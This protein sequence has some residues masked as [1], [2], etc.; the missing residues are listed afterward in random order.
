MT[1]QDLQALVA[2]VSTE[3][4]HRPFT[5][6]ASFNNRLRTTGGRMLLATENLEFNPKVFEAGDEAVRLGI[7]KHELCHYHLHQLHRGFRHRDADFRALLQQ[8]GGLRFTPQ[9]TPPAP[10]RYLYVCT[11]CGTPY[12]RKRRI[13]LRRLRCG[14]C[15]QRLRLV[16]TNGK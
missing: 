15:G 3:W 7:I 11:G 4:F 12:P 16:A 5:N 6:R 14:K 8:V 2:A 13:D 10:P 9:L 1:N